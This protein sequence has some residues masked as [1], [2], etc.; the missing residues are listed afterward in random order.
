M[1]EISPAAGLKFYDAPVTIPGL[2]P[3][4]LLIVNGSLDD[5]CPIEGL[6]PVME[7]AERA[8]ALHNR[9]SCFS[10]LFEVGVGHS[11]TERMKENV[12]DWFDQ[13]LVW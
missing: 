9:S 1:E 5:R 12:I 3:R 2:A 6:Y 13:H 10:Y 8:Y 7:A 4:P 11:A